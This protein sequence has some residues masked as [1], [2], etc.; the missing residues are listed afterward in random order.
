MKN[1]NYYSKI[2]KEIIEMIPP[3][4]NNIL[5]VGCGSGETELILK[6]SGK[7]VYVIER[8][9]RLATELKNKLGPDNVLII[10]IEKNNL[11]LPEN[12]FDCII[13]AD[14]LEHLTDP[15]KTIL[16]LKPFLKNNG[17]FIISIPN[18][19][20]I[21]VI[22]DLIL[23][24]WNYKDSGIMDYT[25]LHFFT[26]D[27]IK[28]LLAKNSL[29]IIEIKRKFYLFLP[30]NFKN[31]YCAYICLKM[32]LIFASKFNPI[33]YIPAIKEFFVYQYLLIVRN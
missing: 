25:H 20:H 12:F 33:I 23:G 4:V 24:N 29:G 7:S 18:I 1:I 31:K 8:E 17:V 3:R 2:R 15:K 6:K 10:D 19:R 11:N 26:I 32:N 28:K 13:L 9:N 30:E 22:K 21:S 16:K 5:S 14:V 27:S